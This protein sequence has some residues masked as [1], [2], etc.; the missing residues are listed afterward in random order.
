[1]AIEALAAVGSWVA[2]YGATA[3]AVGSAATGVYAATKKPETPDVVKPPKNRKEDEIEA[4]R[5][6]AAAVAA[7]QGRESTILTAAT[8]GD[9]LGG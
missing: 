8:D 3:A 5:R 7:R 9:K 1:M 2:E 6:A 4:R